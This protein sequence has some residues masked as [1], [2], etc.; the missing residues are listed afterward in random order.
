M[1]SKLMIKNFSNFS[2]FQTSF[3]EIVAFF[4]F[5]RF[6]FSLSL[7]LFSLEDSLVV[8]CRLFR[9]LVAEG[10]LYLC[11]TFPP[12]SSCLLFNFIGEK[13]YL[14][15][16]GLPSK[17]DINSFFLDFNFDLSNP[18]L[19]LHSYLQ[20]NMIERNCETGLQCNNR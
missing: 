18:F 14:K 15:F 5:F 2:Y 19:A 8:L 11:D 20:R 3:Y 12:P 1:L 9:L 13:N 6:L 17:S 4:A 16:S 7:E 10:S